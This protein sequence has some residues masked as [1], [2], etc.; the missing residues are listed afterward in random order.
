MCPIIYCYVCL[1]YLYW[2]VPIC[3]VPGFTVLT[4][5]AEGLTVAATLLTHLPV[6]GSLCWPIKHLAPEVIVAFGVDETVGFTVAVAF[7]VVAGFTEAIGLIDALVS[8]MQVPLA[9]LCC[10]VGHVPAN[11]A[12]AT[13]FSVEGSMCWP[14]GHMDTHFPVAMS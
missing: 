8:A 4:G 2:P 5:L 11:P 10:P 14:A 6:A 12:V 13:H 9:S 7:T 1:G 3:P